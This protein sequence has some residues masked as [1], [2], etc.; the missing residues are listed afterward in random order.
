M[1]CFARSLPGET[2]HWHGR[3]R[4]RKR[5]S[6]RPGRTA[7]LHEA[8]KGFC[9]HISHSYWRILIVNSTYG[10]TW[11]NTRRKA[12]PFMQHFCNFENAS[13]IIRN[14]HR[15]HFVDGL[16]L[17]LTHINLAHQCSMALFRSQSREPLL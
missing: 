3:S 4:F 9:S 13:S 5:Y 2:W 8:C 15:F 17:K 7:L 12:L 16:E 11:Q 14:S 10:V 1:R 6:D